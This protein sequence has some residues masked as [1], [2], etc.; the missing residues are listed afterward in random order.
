MRKV[1]EIAT[2]TFITND[3]PNV[4]GL[5][6]AGAAD[7]KTKLSQSG[8]FDP[9]LAEKVV[10]IVDV[11]YG[12]ENGFN[13]AITLCE[14]ALGNVKYIQEKKLISKFFEE[15]N[16]DS[17]K[18]I[19]GVE[20]TMRMLDMSA[21]DLLILWENL[22]YIR[23]T[24]KDPANEGSPTII[25][26]KKEALAQDAKT[27]KDPRSGIEYQVVEVAPLN[28]WLI[29]NYKKFGAKLQFISDKSQEGF[30]F[31]KGFGGCGGFLRYSAGAFDEG[32][33]IEDGGDFDP[34][35]DFI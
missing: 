16:V 20:D 11:S 9:R 7:F 34:E 28:E 27:F 18:V 30:Q 13:Q 33:H 31:V 26:L 14:E 4:A 10:K 19:F 29:E 15:I 35:N 17:P 25:Y 21:V 12:F 8:L 2:Q 1:A 3:R 5:V 6:L 24:L 23:I 32:A 22:E